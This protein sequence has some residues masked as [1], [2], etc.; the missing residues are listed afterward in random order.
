[1]SSNKKSSFGIFSVEDEK[2]DSR[3]ENERDFKKSNGICFR[4]EE[5]MEIDCVKC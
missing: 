2:I 5:I 4:F 1:M 3:V